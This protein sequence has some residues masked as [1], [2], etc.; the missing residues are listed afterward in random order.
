M[1]FSM[2]PLASIRAARQSLKPALVR[3]RNSF[4]SWAGIC[5]AGCCV[6]ILLSLLI[7]IVLHASTSCRT[8]RPRAIRGGPL[9]FPP[10]RSLPAA[11][12]F[13]AFFFV[14]R[15]GGFRA[16]RQRFRTLHVVAFLLLVLFVRAGVHVLDTLDQRLIY[17]GLLLRHLRLLVSVSSFRYGIRDFCGEQP[18]GAQRVIISW[19]DPVH[20][21]WVA[22][23]VHDSDHGDAHAPLFFHRNFLGI[24]VD[25]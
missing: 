13:L 6:L 1:A 17:R 16:C 9:D 22:V 15:H 10:P 8:A 5:T 19:N 12:R 4:T 23:R 14:R 24:R 18:D 3:S 7:K 21:V 25:H 2:S 20:H 11:G